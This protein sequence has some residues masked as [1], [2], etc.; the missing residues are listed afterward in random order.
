MLST[1]DLSAFFDEN[2][3][4]VD[5]TWKGCA[6]RGIFDNEF[7]EVEVGEVAVEGTQPRF[8]CKTSD[9]VALVADEDFT[10]GG[11]T[12]KTIRQEPDGTGI[13]LVILRKAA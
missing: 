10:V 2:H 9:V 4:A 7:A 5:A 1:D 13:S 8:M 12:Y 11:V 6:V 3:F